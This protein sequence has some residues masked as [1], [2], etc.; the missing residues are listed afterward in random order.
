M[1]TKRLYLFRHA[2]SAWP[3]DVDDHERPL[4]KRGTKAAPL[5][6]A[7]VKTEKLLPDLALVSTA[8][9]TQETWDL[10]VPFLPGCEKRDQ[11]RIY[12]AHA[13]ELLR[14][15]QETDD[16]VGSLMLVGHNPGLEILA[17]QVMKPM[18]SEAEGR[19][20]KKFPTAALAVLSLNIERWAHL[21]QDSGVLERFVTP[22]MLK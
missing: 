21:G 11:P 10:L 19:L 3:E 4:A 20:K 14:V 17:L 6:G 12:E 7:Y 18:Q 1:N 5:M 22:K 16:S 8:R 9:R 13:E 2:K 15:V